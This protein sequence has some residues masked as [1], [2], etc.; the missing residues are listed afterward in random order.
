MASNYSY[1]NG[2]VLNLATG[3]VEDAGVTIT[4]VDNATDNTF[5]SATGGSANTNTDTNQQFSLSG[6]SVDGTYTN[7]WQSGEATFTVGGTTL[8]GVYNIFTSGGTNYA[9]FIPESGTGTLAE[10]GSW[11]ASGVSSAGFNYSDVSAQGN[12]TITLDDAGPRTVLGG[13]GNDS[14]TGSN[15]ADTLYGGSGSDTILG[16]GGADVI[17]GDGDEPTRQVFE[18]SQL[19]DPSGDGSA[20]DDEDVLASADQTGFASQNL[21]GINVSLDYDEEAN[22]RDV[23]F[24]NSNQ[25]TNGIDVGDTGA[26]NANSSGQLYGTRSGADANTSVLTINFSSTTATLEDE[27]SDVQFRINDIDTAG[28]AGFQDQVTVRA[29]DADGNR[30]AVTLVSG[31]G[32]TAGPTLSDTSGDGFTGVDQALGNTGT[33]NADAAGSI[34]VTVG[35]PVARIEIDYENAGSSNQA[36]TIT[37]IYFTT[38][39][40]ADVGEADSI[41]GGGGADTIYGL[42]GNDTINGGGGAD[43]IDGGAGDDSMTGGNGN[44]VITGGAGNDTLDGGAGTDTLTGGDGFDVFIADGTPDIITDF[45]TATGQNIDDDDQ[46]NNDFVDLSAFYNSGTLAAYNAANG[47]NFGLA[48]NALRDDAADGVLDSAGGLQLTGVAPD[49]LTYDNTNVICFTPGTMIVTPTGLRKVESLQPGDLVATRDNGIRP[50]VWVG[51]RDLRQDEV[52]AKPQLAP[53]HISRGALGPDCPNRDMVVSPQHRIL[54]SGLK[55]ALMTGESE[56]L[57]PAVGL[58]N[59]DTVTRCEPGPVSYL[60]LMCEGHEVIRADGLWTETLFPGDQALSGLTPEARAEV[61]ELFPD[62]KS[63]TPARNMLARDEARWL[64]VM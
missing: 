6:S 33:G 46:T 2:Y 24:Q 61:Q 25:Y 34:L 15:S 56:A 8:T 31:G 63:F 9:F 39:P 1:G 48:I 28:G 32:G 3:L 47:T 40:N 51:R 11:S 29:Y 42:G 14:I 30:I 41:D 62:L 16:R 18:W 60:H 5:T 52:E 10:G 35:G 64:R 45:N 43:Q 20:I 36:A 44:D 17:Y 4:L 38:I 54:L 53:I 57:A 21:G 59:G 13:D 23:T 19:P 12:D 27:V 49:D 22:G 26:I 37:D 50:L 7:E 58:I 55:L